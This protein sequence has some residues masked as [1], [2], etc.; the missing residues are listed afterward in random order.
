MTRTAA[1]T[2]SDG[3][4]MRLLALGVATV[5]A[6]AAGPAWG[7]TVPPARNVVIQVEPCEVALLVGYRPGSGEATEA[8]LRRVASAPRSRAL[9]ALRDVL[10]AHAMGPLSVAVD[11]ERLTPTEVRA[12]I[13]VEPGG[14]RPLVVLLVTFALPAGDALA[15]GSADPRNTRISWQDQ[16]SE[17]VAISDAPAQGRWH[18]GVASFL[19]S[20]V[21]PKGDPACGPPRSTRS[22]SPLASP[23]GR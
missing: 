1:R 2:S 16:A 18:A 6:M 10:A 12:K 8:I 14:G 9:E 17:R 4:A 3:L 22:S 13:G 21:P 15:V 7:H 11:G 20:L 23:Q 19:L 5:V